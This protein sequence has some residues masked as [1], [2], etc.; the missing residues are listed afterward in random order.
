MEENCRTCEHGQPMVGVI[1]CAKK[2]RIITNTNIGCEDYSPRKE[3]RQVTLEDL[4]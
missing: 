1:H 4:E 2:R 3:Q